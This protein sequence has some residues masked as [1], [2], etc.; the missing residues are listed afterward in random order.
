MAFNRPTLAD[1][2][3]R[4][5]TDMASRLRGRSAVLRRSVIGV[6]SRA[7]AGLSHML[8]GHLDYN[9][10]QLLPDTADAE[11]LERWASIWGIKRTSATFASGA[12]TFTGTSGSVIPAGTVLQRDD[13]AEYVTDAE[14]TLSS[15]SASVSVTAR[16]AGKDG[17]LDPSVTLSLL[18]PIAGVDSSATVGPAGITGGA[19]QES[20]ERLRERTLA[21]I[22]NPPH[23]GA[24][25]DYEQWA[26][27][28]ADVTRVWVYPRYT[29]AGTVGVAFVCDDLTPIIPDAAKVQD[30]QDAIDAQRPVTAEATAFAPTAS[31]LDFT[32]SGLSPS[33]AAVKAAIEAELADLIKREAEPGGTILI[34]HIREAIS[35]AAGEHDHTLTAPT[36]DVTHAAGSM[37]VMGTITWA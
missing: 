12:V 33:T 31:P 4:T 29:G 28:V 8:H 32:I 5:N 20:D 19:D 36:A 18:S 37:A 14:A 25:F 24:D 26:L 1:L 30:V 10:R 11:H 13:G 22:Q 17:N 2:I 16:A 34:S 35:V 27:A 15:G 6:L 3:E 23:G 21:R 9:S 7:L